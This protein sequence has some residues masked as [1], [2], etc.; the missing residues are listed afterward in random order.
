MRFEY[1]F[2]GYVTKND[3]LCLDGKTIR[4]G[5]FKEQNGTIVPLV[6]NHAH[7]DPS[8]VLG[9]VLLEDRDDGVYGY[10]SVNDT[11]NGQHA[12]SMVMHGDVDSFSIWANKL[13]LNG[14]DVM[15]G[16][17]R[18][19]SLVF[20]GANPGAHIDNIIAHSDE[21]VD[22]VLIWSGEDLAIEHGV[23]EEKEN[24]ME[25]TN[26]I[27]H[28]DEEKKSGKTVGQVYETLTEE[29]KTAV[30]IIIGLAVEEAKKKGDDSEM[31]HNVFDSAAND[32]YLAHAAEVQQNVNAALKDGKKY[33]SLKE[34]FIAH[35]IDNVNYVAHA[36]DLPQYLQ[37][38]NTMVDAE[39]NP[40][41][42]ANID[43]LFPDARAVSNTPDFI[44]REDAWV[45]IVMNG[46]HRTPFSRIKSIHADITKDEA[47]A[48]GYVKGNR[49][50]EEV[51]PLLR[52]TTTPTT[53]YKKQKLDRDDV[54]DITDLDV[55]AYMKGE[56]RIMLD[57]EIARA[58][59]IGDGRDASSDDKINEGNIRPIV[60]DDDLYTLKYTVDMTNATTEDA[61][62]K[63]FMRM[64][65][66]KRKEYKGSGTPTLFTS[67]DMLSSMLLLEDGIGHVIYDSMEKLCKYLR[68]SSIVTVPQFENWVLEDSITTSVTFGD[69]A[70]GKHQLLGLLVNLTDYNF[71]ADK[72]GAVSMF[73]DFDIDFNQMKYLIETRGSGALVK[74]HSAQAFFVEV[75][76]AVS[77]GD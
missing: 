49:K 15:H 71:G 51:F 63:A 6:W 12:K 58:V 45:R 52:R 35:G 67:E 39:G 77:D 8:K 5:A 21:D 24:N 41:G 76:G 69:G 1:D 61:Q 14:E 47:R 64:I 36:E 28:A 75:N 54:I 62:V 42:I 31:K 16:T 2:S 50:V 46:M 25:E 29:Q 56:M 59:L 32:E 43:Y 37:D 74:P 72:G 68:V 66:K 48:R 40:Y 20:A 53:I 55:V 18:E 26:T 27:S 13:T 11:K 65:V 19:V 9:K 17:I 60:A 70:S 57:E 38:A 33:G 3:L 73:D 34:A 7:N 4:H 30:N 44:R 22:G 10:A 23:F